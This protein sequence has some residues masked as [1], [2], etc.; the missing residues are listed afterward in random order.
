MK[1]KCDLVKKL[2]IAGIACWSINQ[3]L[4]DFWLTLEKEKK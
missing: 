3:E 2:G 4:R 1:S